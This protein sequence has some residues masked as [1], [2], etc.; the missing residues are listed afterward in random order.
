MIDEGYMT[1]FSQNRLHLQFHL[2]GNCNLRCK[3][4]YRTEGNVEPLTTDDVKGIIDQFIVLRDKYNNDHNIRKRGHINLTGGEPF[5]RKDIAEIINYIHSNNK[6]LT[7]GILSN[8]SFIN[9]EVIALLKATDVS[10][11]QLSIDGERNTH[12]E[13]RAPGDY[14]RVMAVAKKLT[15]AGIRVYISFTANAK[16]YTQ[17]PT[18]AKECRKNKITALWSDRIVPIGNAEELQDLIITKALLPDYVANLKKARGSELTQ[19]LHKKTDIQ[20]KRALQFIGSNQPIYE[21]SAGKSLIVVDELGNIMPCRRLP[22]ICGNV[23]TSTLT[24]IYYN[25]PTFID[26]REPCIPQE[27]LKCQHNMS[28][29]GGAKCQS[30]AEYGT[31]KKADP[32]CTLTELL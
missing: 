24:D 20:I 12:D 16:N 25:H 22:I 32:A 31:Y 18:I 5:I 13:L 8:G 15:S 9:D 23:F 29:N 14:N 4:C 17:L 6:S 21:C 3:H 1:G 19:R 26:L 27:C 10:F 28:C 2:T 7:Y 30:Y 11:I